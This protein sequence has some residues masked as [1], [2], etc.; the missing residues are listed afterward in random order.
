VPW[1]LL[2]PG[3]VLVQVLVLELELELEL[4]LV[5]HPLH[6]LALLVVVVV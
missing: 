5:Y 4:R 2:A 6:V 1:L 3:L